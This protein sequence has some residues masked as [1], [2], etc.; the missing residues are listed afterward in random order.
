VSGKSGSPT[1]G[2]PRVPSFGVLT[3]DAGTGVG[4][5]EQEQPQPERVLETGASMWAMV[6][7]GGIGS[8]FWPL[9]GP[10]RPKPLLQLTCERPLIVETVRRLAPLIPPE[11]VLVLTS[12]DIAPGIHAAIPEVP[13]AN[14]LV[15][16]RPLGT[17]AALAWGTE[18]IIRRAGPDTLFTCLHADLAIGFPEL[19]RAALLRGARLAAS[20]AVIVSIG[21]RAT[22]PEPGFGY[23][24][25]GAPLREDQSLDD[26]GATRVERFIEKPGAWEAITLVE[27]GA[28]WHT[29]ILIARASVARDAIAEHVIEVQPGLAALRAHDYDAFAEAVK[30]ISLERGLLERF[31]DLLAILGDFEWDDVGTWASLRRARELD[32]DGNGAV[33]QAHFVECAGN[34][35]HAEGGAVVLYGV[36]HLLVVSLE[37]MTFVTTLEKAA[38]LKPLLDSLPPALRTRAPLP[39]SRA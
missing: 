38:E 4:T 5:M 12:R 8:R 26:G 20:G 25:L 27:S 37:G 15:E 23:L 30:S 19:F 1:N 17:A 2:E 3:T 11:R 7:A 9:S 39:D 36:D 10:D 29:G 34:I 24:R 18:Q 21:A 16:P 33:G 22:R 32:D 28:L 13:E 6:M 35:V 31:P 14:L